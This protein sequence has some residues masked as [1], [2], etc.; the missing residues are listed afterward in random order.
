[1]LKKFNHKVEQTGADSPSQNG[2]LERS[3][4]TLGTM[5]WALLYGASLPAKYW[6]YALAHLVYL[7]DHLV[8]SRTKLTPYEAL[9]GS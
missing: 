4:Q 7:L 2:G 1:M 5:T 6:S 3:N 9:S 8:Q